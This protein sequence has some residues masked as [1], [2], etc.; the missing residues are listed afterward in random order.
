MAS[1]MVRISQSLLA[2][3]GGAREFPLDRKPPLA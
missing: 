1:K 2:V 3:E